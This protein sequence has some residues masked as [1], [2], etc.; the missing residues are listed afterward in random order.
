MERFRKLWDV[1]AEL[2]NPEPVNADITKAA[3]KAHGP[4]WQSTTD[5]HFF[6][7][8]DVV[9]RDFARPLWQRVGRSISTTWDYASSGTAASFLRHAWRFFLYFAYPPLSLLLTVLAAFLI[10]WALAEYSFLLG[11]GAFIVTIYLLIQFFWRRYFVLH[12][13]DLWSFS[14]DYI[15]R[16][17]A[18][19]D[20]KLGR[21]ADEICTALKNKS[22]DEVV[23]VGHSTGG[24]LILDAA[25]RALEQD[26]DIAART[27]SFQILTVGSTA[28]KIGLHPAA[29]WFRDRVASLCANEHV[30]WTEFQCR[31]DIINFFDTDPAELM[32]AK[33]PSRPNVPFVRR[34][35]VRFMVDANTL[36]RIRKNFFRVHYQF[37]FGNSL[38]YY[39][40]FPAICFGPKFLWQRAREAAEVPQ[41][42]LPEANP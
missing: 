4:E 33:Q 7:V 11:A 2:S 42:L 34:I 29:K 36:S 39:Y 10:G 31:T 23:L 3:G 16:D 19:I 27:G 9:Q 1:Q 14:R 24:A 41:S 5:F 38:K 25:A 6:S 21:L 20:A 35:R 28:L 40:D 8:D 17:R 22:Y 26:A 18:D 13:M 32:D 30:L 37:V 15:H 12:L